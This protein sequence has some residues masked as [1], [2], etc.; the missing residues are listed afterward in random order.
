MKTKKDL[1]PIIANRYA[2]A[3]LIGF[4]TLVFCAS[5]WQLDSGWS[6]PL[7]GVLISWGGYSTFAKSANVW[8]ESKRDER[9]QKEKD[10]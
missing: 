6:I 7:C 3:S 2:W 10:I 9:R 1:A 4:S 5:F 8:A